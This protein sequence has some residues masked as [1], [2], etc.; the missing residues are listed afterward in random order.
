MKY[1]EFELGLSGVYSV[2][3]GVKKYS[4][5]IKR[6]KRVV[7]ESSH[8]Y[9]DEKTAFLFGEK[10]IKEIIKS[11][12]DLNSV[13]QLDFE[14]SEYKIKSER[15]EINSYDKAKAKIK[16][17][18]KGNAIALFAILV[19]N[20]VLIINMFISAIDS[21]SIIFS[22]LSCS[23]SIIF[24]FVSYLN[25]FIYAEKGTTLS[26]RSKK[27]LSFAWLFQLFFG[28]G[29]ALSAE[30]L[31]SEKLYYKNWNPSSSILFI[32]FEIVLGIF[33]ISINKIFCVLY[34][35]KIV[36]WIII[37]SF[38]FVWKKTINFIRNQDEGFGYSER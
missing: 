26:K 13:S 19:I 1:R 6:D 5:I 20:I 27:V 24:V 14:K 38:S 33:T 17:C 3:N 8:E 18:D 37:V 34:V 16:K 35:A 11:G 4:L 30:L 10:L 15:K 25:G 36:L 7:Y 23:M 12:K 31:D 29:P 22:I 21:N 9:E 28:K 32:C 2:V